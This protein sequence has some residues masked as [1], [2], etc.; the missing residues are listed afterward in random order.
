MWRG[1]V[2][3][4]MWPKRRNIN[5]AIQ[6]TCTLSSV[7]DNR[8]ISC[9]PSIYL[10]VSP[11]LH[12]YNSPWSHDVLN[13]CALLMLLKIIQWK[14]GRYNN[15]ESVDMKLSAG[16]HQRYSKG[17]L[18]SLLLNPKHLKWGIRIWIS[19]FLVACFERKVQDQNTPSTL[20]TSK[21]C[22]TAQPTAPFCL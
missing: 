14:P 1:H 5:I 11:C 17:I 10:V 18:N 22:I 16:K 2:A 15:A 6:D 7:A 20:F 9:T 4:C 13:W 12:H 21:A 3:L 19:T 8:T